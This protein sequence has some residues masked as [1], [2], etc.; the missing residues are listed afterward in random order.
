[1]DHVFSDP[2]DIGTDRPY[3]PPVPVTIMSGRQFNTT[4]PRSV[5]AVMEKKIRELW[6]SS[7]FK[8]T[9][10]EIFNPN[11]EAS[12]FSKGSKG[13]RRMFFPTKNISIWWFEQAEFLTDEQMRLILPTARHYDTCKITGKRYVNEKW[14]V[15]NPKK[16]TDWGLEAVS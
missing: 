15:W 16:R 10:S 4:L 8:I 12:V 13:T 6:M 11:T 14:F 5:K 3:Y 9:K 2:K 1:M 7:K